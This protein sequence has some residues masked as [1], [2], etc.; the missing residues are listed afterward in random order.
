MNRRQIRSFNGYAHLPFAQCLME[1][2]DRHLIEK[3]R[4][5]YNKSS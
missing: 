1:I 3:T 2:Q 4:T 5:R